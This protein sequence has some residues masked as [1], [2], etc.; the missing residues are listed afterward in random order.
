MELLD[1]CTLSDEDKQ[2]VKMYYL[3]NKSIGYIADILGYSE[4]NI[5]KRHNKILNKLSKLI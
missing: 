2:I 3:Q 4:S 5:K 1:S